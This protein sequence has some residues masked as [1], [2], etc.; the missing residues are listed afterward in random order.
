MSRTGLVASLYAH[1]PEPAVELNPADAHRRGLAAGELVRIESR[2]GVVTVPLA[3]TDDV[4][5]GCAFLPMHWGSMSLPGRG[6]TGINAVTSKALCPSSKQPE[7]K[8]A[9]VRMTRA[10]LPHRLV[11]FGVPGSA[12]A[13]SAMR[14]AVGAVARGFDYASV[15]L[16][17]T[18]RAGVLV[19]AASA[20]PF[21][22][23]SLAALDGCFALD[24][25]EVARY[26]DPRRGVGRRV[27]VVAGRLAAVR[28]SG[29]LRGAAWLHEWLTSAR[30]V[31]A[32]G[33]TLLL[34]SALPPSGSRVRGRVVCVCHDVAESEIVAMLAAHAGTGDA[35]LAAVQSALK[36]GTSCGSCVPELKQLASASRRAA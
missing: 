15:V 10:E 3:L 24:T 28:L 26:D 30:D 23:A 17:G 18:E 11:A 6:G 9:A 33:A 4:K 19:R 2:R 21:D 5:P 36:C 13:L 12:D 8:H 16:I 20:E 32:F 7:L 25:G 29:D 27:S 34:P 1:S 31:G 14:E 35:A 22:A